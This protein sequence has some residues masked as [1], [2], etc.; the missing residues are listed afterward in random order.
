TSLVSRDTLGNAGDGASFEPTISASGQFVAFTSLATNLASIPGASGSQ[1]YLRDVTGNATSLVS[2]DTL[3]N[4]GN[5]ASTHPTISAASGQFVGFSSLATNLAA[6]PG[7]SG[8]QILLRDTQGNQTS[9]I[10]QD[11]GAPASAGNGASTTP[12]I[13]ADGTFVAFSSQ[14]SNL[15]VGGVAPSDIYVRAVP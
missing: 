3:G 7:G 11:N 10:S 14:A 13:V 1:I 5:G 15:V 2:R 8:S 4:A 9:L 6:A 12:S